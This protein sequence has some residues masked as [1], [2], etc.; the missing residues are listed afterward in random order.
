V[1]LSTHILPEVQA[2]CNRIVIIHEGSIVADGTP[3]QLQRDFKGAES[4]SLEIKATARDVMSD[5]F[6][7][8]R[9]VPNVETVETL[10]SEG[11]RHRFT[12]VASKGSDV[13]E[14]LFRRAVDERWTILEMSRR[15]TSLEEVFHALTR[16]EPQNDGQVPR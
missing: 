8:L 9:S 1:I 15:R 2:T 14:E 11:D 10:G 12:V 7:K 16:A 6:P 4:V 3:E 5:L 13:R